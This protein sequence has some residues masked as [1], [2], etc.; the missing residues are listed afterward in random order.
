MLTVPHFGLLVRKHARSQSLRQRKYD[1]NAYLP[2]ALLDRL[3]PSQ[4][5]DYPASPPREIREG[6]IFASENGGI[7][8]RSNLAVSNR[9]DGTL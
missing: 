4:K 5:L 3:P 1:H 8:S 9:K 7:P 2:R 6:R